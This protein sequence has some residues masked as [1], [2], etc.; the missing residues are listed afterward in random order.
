MSEHAMDQHSQQ[1]FF[2]DCE[3]DKP[4]NSLSSTYSRSSWF[5][6]KRMKTTGVEVLKAANMA[7]REFEN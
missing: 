2:C 3:T 4:K 1:Q 5:V 7:Q 6:A